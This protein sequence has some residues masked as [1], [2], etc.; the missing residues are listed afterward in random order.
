MGL[1]AAQVLHKI[2]VNTNY[3]YKACENP[4]CS[5]R[6]SPVETPKSGNVLFYFFA[7][8]TPVTPHQL[9][10]DVYTEFLWN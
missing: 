3:P 6:F 5:A 4:L 9:Q 7:L 10:N 1:G 8:Q 2:T